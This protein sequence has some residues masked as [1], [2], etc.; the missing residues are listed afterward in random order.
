V[1]PRP[2]QG[3][4]G[5][6]GPSGPAGPSGL[7]GPSGTQGPS[8]PAG[9]SGLQGPSGTQGPSGPAGPSGLQG[10]SG[11]QGPSGP[12][13]PSGLQGPSGT[14]GPSGPAGP[15]ISYTSTATAGGTTALNSSSTTTQFWTGTLNQTITLP[16]NATL[17]RGAGYLIGNNSTG[18]LTVQ[19]STAVLI[20]TVAP[21][22]NM[23]VTSIGAT[24]T[25]ADWD[26]S[27]RGYSTITGTGANALAVSPTITNL[28]LAAGTTA[29]PSL[30]LTTGSLLTAAVQGA[31]EWDGNN[32][33]ITGNTTTGSG[34]Q[35]VVSDQRV[36]LA[37][38]ASAI[39]ANT[40]FFPS[41]R[42][43][44]LAGHLYHFR[45]YLT[46]AKNTAGTVTFQLKNS[47]A[48][49]FTN[50]DA[51][52]RVYVQGAVLAII[53]NDSEAH[54]AGTATATFPATASL[55]N[56]AA[57]FAVV[58]GYVVP[59]SNTRLSIAPSAYGAGT[60]NTSIGSNMVITDLGAVATASYG[61][62]G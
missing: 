2:P 17:S 58:E 21:G 14:Q 19:T 6:Q 34:R 32:A 54:A 25:A 11:T 16:D 33:F 40:D 5:T 1:F 39:A 43:G 30:G 12:A 56:N 28:N 46:F 4:S 61:N 38:S 10:P 20:G 26:I 22:L 57:G 23:F 31:L 24:N 51:E 44:I 7:Q 41:L 8:G 29:L 3:P 53:T 47:A 27:F 59:V 48:I 49:N 55:A 60:I 13:G 9:P 37:A 36:W 15:T 62:L 18:S 50:L 45:Y 42:P 52:M 35:I